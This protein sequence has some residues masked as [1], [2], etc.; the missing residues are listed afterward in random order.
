MPL[1]FSSPHPHLLGQAVSRGGEG[2]QSRTNP[3]TSPLLSSPLPPPP[4]PPHSLP[5]SRLLRLSLSTHLLFS[6]TDGQFG[7]YMQVHIQN[8][9]PVTIQ[10]ESPSSPPDPKQVLFPLP[11]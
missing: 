7:G 1:L 10:L 9:G 2:V 6:P 4:S 8:D 3:S 11:L 5:L